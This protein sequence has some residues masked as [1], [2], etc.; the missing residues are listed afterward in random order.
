M[1]AR[2]VDSLG[3]RN[4]LDPRIPSSQQF[5]RPV[6]NPTS[7]IRIGRAT[8]GW[9]VLEAAILWWIVRWRDHDA[10]GEVLGA[11]P[12]VNQNGSGDNRRRSYPVVLLDDRF[13]IVR[14]QHLKRCAL[15]GPGNRMSVFSHVERTIRSLLPP[16]LAN[17]LGNREYVRFGESSMQRRATVPARA[18]ADELGGIIQVRLTLEIIPLQAG[19]IY[20]HLFGSW[21]A[22]E[23]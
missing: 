6:F 2:R 19:H 3:E 17:C 5:V 23:R 9:V 22:G 8:V 15:C 10:V 18:E 20:Q 4:S 13:D 7:H 14:G 21:F 1:C 11:A 12:V 16:V